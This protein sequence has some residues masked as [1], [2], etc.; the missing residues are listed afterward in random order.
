VAKQSF[1]DKLGFLSGRLGTSFESYIT[2]RQEEMMKC[3]T[4]GSQ[5]FFIKDPE[6]EYTTYEFD[7]HDEQ[8][9]FEDETQEVRPETETFC[10]RCSWHDRFKT[11]QQ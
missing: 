9:V 4:C 7:L 3:P 6:D 10:C 1:A 2:S 8:P 5:R 11:L